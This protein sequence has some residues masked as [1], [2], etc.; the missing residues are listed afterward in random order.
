M[1]READSA[2]I[3]LE[4]DIAILGFE[5]GITPSEVKKFIKGQE[6]AHWER[7]ISDKG[8]EKMY[9]V[10]DLSETKDLDEWGLSRLNRLNIALLENGLILYYRDNSKSEYD[11]DYEKYVYE[12]EKNHENDD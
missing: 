7:R 9:I 2:Y 5:G 3:T 11:S 12:W 10:A 4:G 8:K 1:T 6:W